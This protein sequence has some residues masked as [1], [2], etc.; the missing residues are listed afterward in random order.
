M[1]AAGVPEFVDPFGVDGDGGADAGEGAGGAEA[2]MGRQAARERGRLLGLGEA[3][4]R[5]EIGAVRD[6]RVGR[7]VAY[8]EWEFDTMAERKRRPS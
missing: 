8:A 1:E 3:R 7:A 2:V 4:S 5:G 6:R